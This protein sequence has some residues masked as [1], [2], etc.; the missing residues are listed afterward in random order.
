MQPVWVEYIQVPRGDK[1]TDTSMPA[2]T[3]AGQPRLHYDPAT[4]GITHIGGDNPSVKV[5]RHT[6]PQQ[7]F[8]LLIEIMNHPIKPK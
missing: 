4:F 5:C 6:E 1:W 2:V 8:D 3:E 7:A